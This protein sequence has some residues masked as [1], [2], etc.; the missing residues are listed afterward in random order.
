[1]RIISFVGFSPNGGALG[2]VLRAIA[3]AE[4]SIQVAAYSFTSQPVAVALLDAHKQGVTVRVIA[5]EA[6][7]KG[8][9][10]AV[11]FLANQGVPVRVNGRYSICHRKFLIVDGRHIQTG[12][13]NYSKAAADKNA[14]NALMLWNVS[15]L[16]REYDREWSR[17][18]VE[19]E[20]ISRRY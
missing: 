18:W 14:E 12:S 11:T 5:D 1:M 16:A 15:G 17:L 3:Q 19:S 9:Y 8:K 7:G 2:L 6:S 4:T 13:F 10:S 20:A